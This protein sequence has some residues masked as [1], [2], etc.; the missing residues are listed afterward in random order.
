MSEPT[1]LDQGAVFSPDGVYRYA[2]WRCWDAAKPLV[3][4]NLCNPSK[5]DA[6]KLDPTL[7]RVLG[8]SQAWGFGGFW[9]G[10]IF[11]LKSTD[12]SA[13]YQVEDPVGPE[14]DRHLDEIAARCSLLVAGWGVHGKLKHR[15]DTVRR[16]LA[17][18]GRAL[19]VLRLSKDGHP[20][21]PLYLPGSLEPKP[22]R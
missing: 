10:N 3:G 17:N 20:A 2:L 21:H 16:R 7:R 1:Y 14:N 15:G 5:A 4:F 6:E 12:P 8:F 13:L 9:I 11:G 22:W 18:A 19:Y